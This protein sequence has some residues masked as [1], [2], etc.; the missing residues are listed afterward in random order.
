MTAV[1]MTVDYMT[2]ADTIL[3]PINE[4][5][6]TFVY[7]FH[8]RV[9]PIADFVMCIIVLQWAWAFVSLAKQVHV[10]LLVFDTPGWNTHAGAQT[11]YWPTSKCHVIHGTISVHSHD[12]SHTFIDIAFKI[13][14]VFTP[15]KS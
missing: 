1:Y 10:G 12:Y 7:S 15:L 6:I 2:V 13:P 4:Q 8:L 14:P 11:D 3:A 9:Q 5:L